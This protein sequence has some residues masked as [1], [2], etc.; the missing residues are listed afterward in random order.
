MMTHLKVIFQDLSVMYETQRQYVDEF[1]SKHAINSKHLLIAYEIPNRGFHLIAYDP[2]QG[3]LC[4]EREREITDIKI[5]LIIASEAYFYLIE[6]T[7]K[8]NNKHLIHE[9]DYELKRTRTA[10]FGQ[11]KWPKKPF[12][13]PLSADVFAVE[14]ERV[15]LKLESR[16][17]VFSRS[18]GL[19]V[20]EILL[21]DLHLSRVFLDVREPGDELFLIFNGYQKVSLYDSRGELVASNK[22]RHPGKFDEFQFIRAGYFGF[23]NSDKSIILIV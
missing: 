12:Y 4:Q 7:D 13:I 20:T 11:N 23:I 22:I 8:P 1:Y 17:R 2:L 16:I 19:A 14:L 18:T 9:F 21:D 5:D 15:Y 3:Q 6:D 10:G